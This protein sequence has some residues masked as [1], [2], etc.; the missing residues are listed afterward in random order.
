MLS[1]QKQQKSII[2]S[3]TGLVWGKIETE[4]SIFRDFL[5]WGGTLKNHPFLHGI[6]PSKP[7][8]L[9]Y[10]HGHGN[11][12]MSWENFDGFWVRFSQPNQSIDL[13]GP[14][15]AWRRCARRNSLEF[16]ATV[17]FWLSK[18]D[19]CLYWNGNFEWGKIVINNYTYYLSYIILKYRKISEHMGKY[20]KI[21]RQR[22]MNRIWECGPT[23]LR[24]F[25]S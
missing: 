21:W 16:H 13:S 8:I 9:G 18:L 10:H 4:S 24:G 2:F 25:Q 20:Q 7:S 23:K 22:Q 6:F 19:E 3:Q 17:D 15:W 1:S 11:L 5:K 14:R 12:H